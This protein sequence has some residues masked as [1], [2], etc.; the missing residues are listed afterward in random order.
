[1]N[2][3]DGCRN[4][5]LAAA[6][7]L[8]A[9]CGSVEVPRERFFRLALPEVAA[10]DPQKAG[11]LRV[12]DLQLGTALDSDCLLVATGVQLEPR[13]LERWV[14]PL[15]RLVTDALVLGLSRA[16]VCD[17][18]K[19]A[20]DPGDETWSLRGRIVEFAEVH[21]GDGERAH[22]TIELWLEGDGRLLFRQEFAATE[23]LQGTG[24]EAAVAA[25]SRGLQQ[26][27][28]GVVARMRQDG[29]FAAARPPAPP[30]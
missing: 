8:L 30:R 29:L 22:V 2:Q 21:D 27:V 3:P 9:A 10:V 4:A 11:V 18:V 1:M 23:R 16:Q 28:G 17:L 14:A 19:G 26:V 5:A 13:P 6:A 25:L 7:F 12:A 20:A 24:A 15:D